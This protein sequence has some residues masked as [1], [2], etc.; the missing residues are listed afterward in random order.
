MF[1]TK[2]GRAESPFLVPSG[3]SVKERLKYW[4]DLIGVTV[5]NT[6]RIPKREMV[7]NGL[8][9]PAKF[10]GYCPDDDTI[11]YQGV[12]TDHDIIHELLHKKFPKI[13]R[14]HY[15]NTLTAIILAAASSTP[16]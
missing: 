3:G 9:V 14:H 12:L 5:P 8:N 1:V 10:K 13:K 16:P 7:V 4:S 15:I 2:K 11:Y 6:Y